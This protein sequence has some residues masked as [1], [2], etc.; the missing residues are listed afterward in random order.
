MNFQLPSFPEKPPFPK[1]IRDGLSFQD[2]DAALQ[3]A[4]QAMELISSKKICEA[5]DEFLVTGE[6]PTIFFMFE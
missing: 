1:K 6:I 4:S 3:A 5:S 2:F